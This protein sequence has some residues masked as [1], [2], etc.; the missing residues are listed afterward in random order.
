MTRDEAKKI[1]MVISAS[2]PNFKP[3]DIRMTVDVWHTMLEEYSYMQ[4]SVAL[5]AYIASDTSGFAPSIGQVVGMMKRIEEPEELNEMEAWALVSRAIR[6]GYYGAEEEFAKLPPLIQRT[7]GTPGQ[8]RNW[9]QTDIES[10]EN[11]IQSNFMR[12][13]RSV[14][15]NNRE[16]ARMPEN[17]RQMIEGTGRKLIGGNESASL[18]AITE[19]KEPLQEGVPMP[20]RLMQKFREMMNE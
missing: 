5:K 9:S 18:K 7:V 8:L 12:T 1:V 20:E 3:Q 17:I 2:Y 19:I 15:K 6:N 10:I 16:A 13:Y 11:V 4:V 14:V